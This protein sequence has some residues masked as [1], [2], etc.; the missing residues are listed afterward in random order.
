V[1]QLISSLQLTSDTS[2]DPT[3]LPGSEEVAAEELSNEDLPDEDAFDNDFPYET[4]DHTIKIA[5]G[6]EVQGNIVNI[7]TWSKKGEG[8]H[9]RALLDTGSSPNIIRHGKAIETGY[10]MEPYQGLSVIAAD[11]RTF[12]PV[13]YVKLQW[14]FHNL[15][16]ERTYTVKF[17]IVA[18]TL[19]FDVIIGWP[20]IRKIKLFTWNPYAMMTFTPKSQTPGKPVVPVHSLWTS[21]DVWIEEQEKQRKKK[22]AQKKKGDKKD[23][24]YIEERKRDSQSQPQRQSR[25]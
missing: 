6:A 25:P 3:P 23:Q 21:T 13:G 14:H 18:D 11:G 17:L 20:F 24:Q 7:R 10:E 22:E 12:E 16:H 15:R 5:T 2:N 9:M 4:E 8:L 1:T 19:P